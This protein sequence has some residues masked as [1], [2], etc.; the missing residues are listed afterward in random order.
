MRE[1]IASCVL[2]ALVFV[3]LPIVLIVGTDRPAA[4]V[5]DHSQCAYLIERAEKAADTAEMAS[6]AAAANADAT[7]AL[8]WT[9]IAIAEGCGR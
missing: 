4:A 1:L 2:A 8:A 5:A 6:F 3:V 9:N 7:I